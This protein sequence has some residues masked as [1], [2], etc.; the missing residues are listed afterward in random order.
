MDLQKRK[1]I[2][3]TGREGPA[4]S[5]NHERAVR[6]GRKERRKRI[7]GKGRVKDG[8]QESYPY[9][10][11]IPGKGRTVRKPVMR[12]RFDRLC[13]QIENT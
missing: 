8:I 2:K 11:K 4:E 10:L 9:G 13:E 5:E 1:R 6:G 12:A 7:P 3:K